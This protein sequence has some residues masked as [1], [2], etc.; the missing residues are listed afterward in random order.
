MAATYRSSA[1]GCTKPVP[2][3]E[4]RRATGQQSGGLEDAVDA[5]GAAGDDIG[6]E[7]HVR[8]APVA[9]ERILPRE[10]D[11]ASLFVGRQPMVAGNPGVVFVHLAEALFPVVELAGADAHPG[12]QAARQLGLVGPVRTKSTT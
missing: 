7:H 11:D 8:Q 4:G 10:R 2:F 5:G 1:N 6:V 3:L 12:D 9:F